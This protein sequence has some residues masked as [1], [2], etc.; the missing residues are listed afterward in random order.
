MERVEVYGNFC[1][2]NFL[3]WKKNENNEF[4]LLINL[5]VRYVWCKL[6]LKR[7]LVFVKN[8]NMYINNLYDINW[9]EIE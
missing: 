5:Y 3:L 7:Y 4:V 9:N 8:V 1:I 2:L 6:M